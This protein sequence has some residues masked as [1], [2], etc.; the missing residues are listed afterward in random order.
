M[1][2]ITMV[3]MTSY[4]NTYNNTST[5]LCLLIH[6][7][8]NIGQLY[9]KYGNKVQTWSTHSIEEFTRRQQCFVDQY[10]AFDYLGAQVTM[11]I[12]LLVNASVHEGLNCS[13]MYTSDSRSMGS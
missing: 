5:V 13:I 1:D 2:L 7:M 9:D 3:M 8:L 12:L 11:V 10:S 4:H 6:C